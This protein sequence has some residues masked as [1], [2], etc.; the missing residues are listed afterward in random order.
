MH[1]QDEQWQPERW[2]GMHVH[3]PSFQSEMPVEAVDAGQQLPLA[4][5]QAVMCVWL[6]YHP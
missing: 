5:H 2:C 3:L 6:T 4:K 1:V